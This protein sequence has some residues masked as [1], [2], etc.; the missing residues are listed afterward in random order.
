MESNAG[1]GCQLVDFKHLVCLSHLTC[2]L[3]ASNG[4]T[5]FRYAD[6]TPAGSIDWRDHNAVT[7][8]KNQGQVRW[9][10]CD[11]FLLCRV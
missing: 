2:S 7:E 1:N 4:H 5:P 11:P 9:G 3:A 8:V 6:V 10:C